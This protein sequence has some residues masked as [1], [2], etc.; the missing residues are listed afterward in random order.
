ML[1]SIIA[2]GTQDYV[3]GPVQLS[4]LRRENIGAFRPIDG[5]LTAKARELVD[6]HCPLPVASVW[7][8]PHYACEVTLR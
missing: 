4:D 6:D 2:T 7:L 8:R 1:Q 3:L 5:A